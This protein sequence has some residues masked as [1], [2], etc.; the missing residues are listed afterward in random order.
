MHLAIKSD[1]RVLT[2][3][4]YEQQ[5]FSGHWV[6]NQRKEYSKQM[7]SIS[8]N[9]S[10]NKEVDQQNQQNIMIESSSSSSITD[11]RIEALNELGFV[12][13]LRKK[14]TEVVGWDERYEE[15][16]AYKEH[17]GDCNVPQTYKKNMGLARWVNKKRNQYKQKSKSLTPQQ[18][19]A[20][21]AIGFTWSMFEKIWEERYLQLKQFQY[22]HDIGHN[23]DDNLELITKENSQLG[24]WVKK[25]KQEMKKFRENKKSTLT[26][27]RIKKLNDLGF[28]H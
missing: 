28:F 10:Y 11:D 8:N 1:E 16:I 22:E 12:W 3:I 2:N 13:S 20:L 6:F 14:P 23:I 27:A 7:K 24:S 4:I 25:Q 5:S 17:H 15:L 9:N 18:I 21:N 19:D 26:D